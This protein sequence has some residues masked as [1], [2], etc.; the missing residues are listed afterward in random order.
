MVLLAWLTQKTCTMVTDSREERKRTV[1]T[2][3]TT[4]HIKSQTG[5]DGHSQ[6]TSAVRCSK[7]VNIWYIFANHEEDEV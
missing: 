6:L 3:F 1:S 4:E 5:Q 7:T 2:T